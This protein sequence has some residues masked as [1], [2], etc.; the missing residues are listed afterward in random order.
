MY[1]KIK[2]KVLIEIDAKKQMKTAIQIQYTD[3]KQNVKGT[4]EV[5]VEYEWRPE[6]CS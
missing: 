5:K 1:L 2:E 3:N 4:K 6:E